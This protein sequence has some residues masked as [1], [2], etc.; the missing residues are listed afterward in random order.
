MIFDSDSVTLALDN[1][2]SFCLTNNVEDF[3][4]KP[5]KVYKDLLGLG[6]AQVSYV[7]TV[8]WSFEDDKGQVHSWPM[9]NTNYSPDTPIRLF[10]LQHWAQCNRQLHAHS[11]TDADR[12]TLEW[13]GHIRTV[14][15]NSANVGFL[16]TALGYSASGKVVSAINVMLPKEL[17]CFPVHLIPPDDEEKEEQEGDPEPDLLRYPE[18]HLQPNPETPGV[19]GAPLTTPID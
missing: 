16:R 17:V 6:K 11:D 19:Q 8:L 12:I 5:R 15:L 14:P 18:Y 9:L 13:D 3:I 2:S 4:T 10:S 7:G 1:C